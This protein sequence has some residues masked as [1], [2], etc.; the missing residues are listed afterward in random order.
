MALIIANSANATSRCQNKFYLVNNALF[1]R[2][3][4]SCI[5]LYWMKYNCVIYKDKNDK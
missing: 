3:I 1:C 4:I 2:W 5:V